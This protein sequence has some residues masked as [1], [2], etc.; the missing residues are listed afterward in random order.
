MRLDGGS[1]G[2]NANSIIKKLTAQ[3]VDNSRNGYMKTGDVSWY[4][5]E[6]PCAGD[7]SKVRNVSDDGGLYYYGDACDS[8]GG[9][10]P[11]LCLNSDINI[12]GKGIVNESYVM[13]MPIPD[14]FIY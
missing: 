3:A 7:S 13:T 10:V 8:N 14:P 4:F 9:V 11:A 2:L 6:T 1:W 12:S 5:L